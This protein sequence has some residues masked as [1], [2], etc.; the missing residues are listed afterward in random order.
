MKKTDTFYN[1]ETMFYDM[2]IDT[3]DFVLTDTTVE[4]LI[5]L[6]NAGFPMVI[7][8][9]KVTLNN[10]RDAQAKLI[11][12]EINDHLVMESEFHELSDYVEYKFWS[13]D[14]FKDEI[15]LAIQETIL[16]KAYDVK[17]IDVFEY[18]VDTWILNDRE[19]ESLKKQK[20]ED[21]REAQERQYH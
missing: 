18:I 15:K 14:V 20:A 16:D 5:Y 12:D 21:Y 13:D 10:S 2:P 1:C 8:K 19:K 7:E 3:P 4:D 6:N 11:M 17:F 9:G